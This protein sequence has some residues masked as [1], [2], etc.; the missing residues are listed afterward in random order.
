MNLLNYEMIF[1][2][3][4]QNPHMKNMLHFRIDYKKKIVLGEIEWNPSAELI[5]DWNK[6]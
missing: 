2:P 1:S 3:F 5:E 4:F 6:I